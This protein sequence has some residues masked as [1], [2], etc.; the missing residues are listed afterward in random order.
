M[1]SSSLSVYHMVIYVSIAI[2]C[3]Y[4]LSFRLGIR[5]YPQNRKLSQTSRNVLDIMQLFV[6][7]VGIML[8]WRGMYNLFDLYFMPSYPF[9]GNLTASVIGFGIILVM[10]GKD[11]LANYVG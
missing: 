3:L 9:W 5:V 2:V 1:E 4:A 8:V 11:A 7:A 6:V 10:G